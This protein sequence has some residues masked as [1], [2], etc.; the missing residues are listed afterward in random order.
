MAEK[1]R[2]REAK[3]LTQGHTAP[4]CHMPGSQSTGE[5]LCAEAA[6]VGGRGRVASPT[7][8]LRPSPR[9]F[10]RACCGTGCQ[11]GQ[12]GEGRGAAGLGPERAGGGGG[13]F[14]RR[15]QSMQ[16]VGCVRCLAHCLGQPALYSPGVGGMC[17]LIGYVAPPY[18]SFSIH[19]MGRGFRICLKWWL[20][21]TPRGSP[22]V[23]S[24][25]GVICCVSRGPWINKCTMV[26]GEGC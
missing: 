22:I 12:C 26:G 7:L 14:P 21:A 24:G 9:P 11:R 16:K 15:G 19:R 20:S 5:G 13:R 18:L 4:P 3:S 23:N 6:G 2:H 17:A 10:L 1:R 25:L 8:S